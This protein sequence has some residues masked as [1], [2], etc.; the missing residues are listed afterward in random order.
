MGFSIEKEFLP[1]RHDCLVFVFWFQERICMLFFFVFCFLSIL[2]SNLHDC[3]FSSKATEGYLR[4]QSKP[5]GQV[6]VGTNLTF[7]LLISWLYC[8]VNWM[9][10]G[11]ANTLHH[12]LIFPARCNPHID[13][14]LYESP[15]VQTA[16]CHSS[17]FAAWKICV[18]LLMIQFWKFGVTQK[19]FLSYR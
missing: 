4:R 15:K 5:D 13:C 18:L 14:V 9:L 6:T 17:E 2:G 11:F 8:R 12:W 10:C 1:S 16:F 7:N 19:P 3:R